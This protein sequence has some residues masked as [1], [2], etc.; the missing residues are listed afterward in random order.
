MN[1]RDLE[2]PRRTYWSDPRPLIE[3][4]QICSSLL[5]EQIR[6]MQH[7]CAGSQLVDPE[8][9]ATARA[10]LNLEAEMWERANWQ[11]DE[12]APTS[13]NGVPE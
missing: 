6:T 2:I 9:I 3:A 12:F 10:L 8:E 4:L 5:L 13:E 11:P 1:L 7:L